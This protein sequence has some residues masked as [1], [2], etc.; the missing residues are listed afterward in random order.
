MHSK[1]SN[2]SLHFH[3]EEDAEGVHQTARHTGR[4]D[5]VDYVREMAENRISNQDRSEEKEKR[6]E[7]E[8]G[9]MEEDFFRAAT[10]PYFI[11]RA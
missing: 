1:L 3:A 7:R 6:R 10:L 11:V 8:G 4:R 5:V 9:G 2:K